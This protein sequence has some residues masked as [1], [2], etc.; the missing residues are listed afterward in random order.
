MKML[1]SGLFNFPIGDIFNINCWLSTIPAPTLNLQG[2]R[3]PDSEITLSLAD[4][5]VSIAQTNFSVDCL[6]CSGPKFEELSALFDAPSAHVHAG[7]S[8]ENVLNKLLSLVSSE[9]SMLQTELDRMLV[10]APKFCPHR[11]EYDPYAVRTQYDNYDTIVPTDD[12]AIFLLALIVAMACFA[13]GVLVITCVLRFI[14]LRRNRRWLM[15]LPREQLIAV[16]E[17]QQIHREHAA[18]M[19]AASQSMITSKRLP[20]LVRLLVPVVLLANVGLF[21]SGRKSS[22]NSRR[23]FSSCR[24]PPADSHNPLH[25]Q[26]RFTDLNLGGEVQIYF[27]LGGERIVISDFYSFSIAQSGVELWNAGAREL[28]VSIISTEHVLITEYYIARL[29]NI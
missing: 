17:N 12:D 20:L 29:T 6:D 3:T 26:R 13:V 16:Y 25:L 22:L 19:N 27:E 7:Q 23:V 15:S 11:P 14:V 1:E 2:L 10:D 4:L 9:H 5:A 21:L 24:S 8:F 18:A 28:A